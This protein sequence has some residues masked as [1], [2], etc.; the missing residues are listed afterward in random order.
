M[1]SNPRTLV[2]LLV[3]LVILANLL[4]IYYSEIV[5]GPYLQWGEARRDL[6]CPDQHLHLPWQRVLLED[7][8]T[9]LMRLMR[10]RDYETILG[11]LL[12]ILLGTLPD[13]L[14]FF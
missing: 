9:Q 14:G 12:G 2:N 8:S 3:I 1:Q 5:L 4:V 13:R 10:L 7:H 11:L 6:G